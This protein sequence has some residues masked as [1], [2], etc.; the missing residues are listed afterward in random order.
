MRVLAVIAA[1]AAL[2]G[3][4]GIPYNQRA[5]GLSMD[6]TKDQVVSQMGPPRKTAARKNADG[7]LTERYFWWSPARIGLA[8]V[9]NEM[10]SSDRV[11]V[12]FTNGHVSEWGDKYD[13]TASMDK[14]MDMH[15]NTIRALKARSPASAAS[16]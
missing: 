15:A 8:S 1:V 6:M 3:C 9:D 2:A 14:A 4:A 5:M 16:Q 10:L 7:D 12:T 13:Y 11:F